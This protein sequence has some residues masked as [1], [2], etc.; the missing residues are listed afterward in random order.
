M[1]H[2]TVIDGFYLTKV[3]PSVDQTEFASSQYTHVRFVNPVVYSVGI[4]KLNS[5][6]IGFSV[7]I[8]ATS[9]SPEPVVVPDP[10]ESSDFTLTV[11]EFE[12]MNVSCVCVVITEVCSMS[13][14]LMRICRNSPGWTSVVGTD[15]HIEFGR[16]I[17]VVRGFSVVLNP[18]EWT[19]TPL[20]FD[21]STMTLVD[22]VVSTAPIRLRIVDSIF[23]L[24]LASC[25]LN[26]SVLELI[27]RRISIMLSKIEN[28]RDYSFVALRESV[29]KTSATCSNASALNV[30]RVS[31]HTCKRV[32][33]Y[34]TLKIYKHSSTF[35][36]VEGV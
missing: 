34:C 3:T 32:S 9:M 11:S 36:K 7:R 18:S 31:V 15:M 12:R 6:S 4:T 33:I 24:I 19:R 1:R 35:R 21:W 10:V 25:S 28:K 27:V 26:L 23:V 16:S 8:D 30:S 29:E 20:K 14:G 17:E 5:N 22:A 2:V 13:K